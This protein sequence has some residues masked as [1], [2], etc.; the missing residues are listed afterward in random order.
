M[1]RVFGLGGVF[2][3]VLGGVFG[4]GVYLLV[5]VGLGVLGFLVV[6]GFLVSARFRADLRKQQYCCSSGEFNAFSQ[7]WCENTS[8]QSGGESEYYI[9][10]S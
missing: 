1:G 8:P 6:I 4:L 3:L 2:G 10:L 5:I 7:A 9:G